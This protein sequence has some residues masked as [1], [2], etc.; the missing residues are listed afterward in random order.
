MKIVID[1]ELSPRQKKIIR[2]AVV[3]GAVIGA[4]GLGLAVAAPHQWMANQP[5]TA[6]DLNSLDIVS[7]D[8]GKQYSLGATYKAVTSGSYN[9]SQVNGYPG[10]KSVCETQVGSP[11]AHMCTGEELIRSA[12]IGLPISATDGGTVPSGWYSSGSR[13]TVEGTPTNSF[14]CKGWTDGV[15]HTLAG[16]YWNGFPNYGFCDVPGPVMCCD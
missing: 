11:S 6:A 15:T 3:T 16:S 5:L 10:A 1:L 7:T 14:D 13:A 9:G 2:A 12:E 4:L 8:A